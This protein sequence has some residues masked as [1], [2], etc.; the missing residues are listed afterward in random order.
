MPEFARQTEVDHPCGALEG[1]PHRCLVAHQD[2]R[3]LVENDLEGRGARV[4]IRNQEVPAAR[5]PENRVGS[6]PVHGLNDVHRNRQARPFLLIER[7]QP[8]TNL[9][10]V[11]SQARLYVLDP[12]TVLLILGSPAARPVGRRRNRPEAPR[13]LG[14]L[15][16]SGIRQLF[17]EPGELHP[18]QVLLPAVRVGRRDDLRVVVD[19]AIPGRARGVRQ[20]VEAGRFGPGVEELGLTGFACDARSDQGVV[21]I[22]LEVTVEDEMGCR[23]DRGSRAGL[24]EARVRRE[25]RHSHS[26]NDSGLPWL[27]HRPHFSSALSPQPDSAP[28]QAP[29]GPSNDDDAFSRRRS[30]RRVARGL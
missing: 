24:S 8:G 30:R 7:L 25:E 12:A 27:P 5:V 3:G 18:E 21:Q 19:G 9:R 22:E 11:S 23:D 2:V 13:D 15:P 26:E 14:E 29:P 10:L 6:A 16:G 1:L 4:R 28:G 17:V 20:L